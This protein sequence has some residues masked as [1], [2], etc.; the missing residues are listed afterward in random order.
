MKGGSEGDSNDSDPTDRKG[1]DG[2]PEWF[3][4]GIIKGTTCTVSSF[5]LPREDGSEE[6]LENEA[7]ERLL[8]K[9][10]LQVSVSNCA[11]TSIKLTYTT[12]YYHEF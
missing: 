5:Y 2:S 12:T 1:R 4:V 6:N 8:R 10:D 11:L 7:D 9:I 3:D